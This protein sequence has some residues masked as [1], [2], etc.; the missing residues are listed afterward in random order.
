[1]TNIRHG[2]QQ[3]MNSTFLGI[4]NYLKKSILNI[5][6]VI[7]KAETKIFGKSIGLKLNSFLSEHLPPIIEIMTEFGSINFYCPGLLP[8]NR[9]NSLLTKEPDTIKW[10][11]SFEKGAVFWDIGANVGVFSLYAALRNN[12]NVLAFEPSANNYWILNK[13]ID[14]NKL[15]DKV[16][17]FCLAFNN[18]SCMDYFH[19]HNTNAGAAL[20]SFGVSVDGKGNL[21]V[22][23]FKQG[24][25]AMTIDDFII[26]FKPPF[27]N[28]MKIDVDGL[29]DKIIYGSRNTLMNSDLKSLCIELN[30][31]RKSY[32]QEIINFLK[33]CGMKLITDMHYGSPGHDVINCIFIRE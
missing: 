8:L 2:Y 15:D 20:H 30:P 28:Y 12:N 29:E 26:N 33:Q 18:N 11:D 27:P 1:M 32:C 3:I 21:F 17:A 24:M 25:L 13:N 5:T 10:I 23:K 31:S 19:L 16:M 6:L 22:A 4:K 7:I 9:A 14:I